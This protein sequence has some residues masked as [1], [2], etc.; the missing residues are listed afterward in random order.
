MALKAGVE[1]W[2][3]GLPFEAVLEAWATAATTS[4]ILSVLLEEGLAD[5]SIVLNEKGIPVPKQGSGEK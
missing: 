5:G 4:V 1:W 3:E 2:K